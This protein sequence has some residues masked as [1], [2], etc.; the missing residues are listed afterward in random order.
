M[1]ALA[2]LLSEKERE[3]WQC[4]RKQIQD[5]HAEPD[6][7]VKEPK[8]ESNQADLPKRS[9]VSRFVLAGQRIGTTAGLRAHTLIICLPEEKE[10]SARKGK[11]FRLLLKHVNSAKI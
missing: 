2:S 11:P 8:N 4:W 10:G 3:G 1:S 9:S 6:W 5:F 7:V